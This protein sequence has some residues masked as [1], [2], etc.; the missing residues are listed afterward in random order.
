[1]RC[2]IRLLLCDNDNALADALAILRDLDPSEPLYA[3]G[4]ALQADA[5][6]QKGEFEHALVLYHRGMRLRIRCNDEEFKLGIQKATD[7]IN[8]SLKNVKRKVNFDLK[9]F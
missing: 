4:L 8:N 6:F 3:K 2:R 5:L 9:S 7:S 1:M